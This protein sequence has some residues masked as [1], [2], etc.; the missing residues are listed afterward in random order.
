MRENLSLVAQMQRDL[1][2]VRWPEPAEIR[3]RARR[4]SR[5]RAAVV[6][7][8]VVAVAVGSAKAVVGGP[9]R[10]VVVPTGVDRP[11]ST[12]A[13]AP[14]RRVEFS[15]AALLTSSDV[16]VP[17]NLRLG[18]SGMGKPVRLD[19]LLESCLD[20][21]GLPPRPES[22]YSRSQTLLQTDPGAGPGATGT[23][24]VSQDLYRLAPAEANGFFVELEQ[25]VA[26]CGG[27]AS[28]GG[29]FSDNGTL[30]LVRSTHSWQVAARGFAGTEA[31]LLRYSGSRSPKVGRDTP[32]NFES[33][34]D[35]TVIVRVGDLVSVIVPAPDL[36]VDRP[37]AGKLVSRERL[38]ALGRAAADRMCLAANP[39]CR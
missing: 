28:E 33:P 13:A 17:T 34:T 21:R 7:A 15:P 10:D 31:V 27:W 22:R 11:P 19:G 9:G 35:V 8:I 2:D 5:R 1:R 4:R 18:E 39:E 37:E 3:D 23:V 38:L 20:E 24:V 25:G 30:H 26:A 36:G 32:A 16:R 14:A 29:E 12:A 6:A